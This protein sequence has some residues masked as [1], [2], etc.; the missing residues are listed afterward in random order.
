[1]SLGQGRQ[2][3]WAPDGSAVLFVHVHQGQ[4]FLFAGSVEA[5]HLTPQAFASTAP[6]TDP[7]WSNTRLPTAL[8][9][10]L[11]EEMPTEP[12]FDE[13]ISPSQDDGPQVLLQQVPFVAP[14]PFLSDRVDD[15][16]RALA[17]R[18]EAESG[19]AL[20]SRLDNMF[21]PLTYQA[22]PGSDSRTWN[23]AGRAFDLQYRSA[24]A[25]DPLLEIVRQDHGYE[26][27]W[28]VYLRT[29]EQNGTQGEPLRELPWDFRA[30]YGQDARYYDE[31]GKWKDAIPTGYYVNFTALA[32]DYGWSRVPAEPTWRTFFPGI[33]FWHFEKRQGL[34]WEVAMA[35]YS[36]LAFREAARPQLGSR[37][38]RTVHRGGA[39]GSVRRTLVA[40]VL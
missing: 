28:T 16:F 7:H 17:A 1:M 21:E 20:L 29:A 12:L 39:G 10:L 15:A 5:W 25:F 2:P 8:V 6:L 4:S 30:R 22:S 11:L 23:K 26:V 24:L 32:A 33:R 27:Y 19:Q 3:T 13:L 9:T 18:T 35:W 38:G 37:H 31:G 40:G 34:S 14:A 36:L